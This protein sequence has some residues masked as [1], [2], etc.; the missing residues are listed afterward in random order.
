MTKILS[1]SLALS[2]SLLAV[3][4]GL[5]SPSARV[6]SSVANPAGA[7][8]SARTEL[9]VLTDDDLN[10]VVE[11]YC[12]RCHSDRRLTGNLS[13]EDYDVARAFETADVS[14]KLILKLRAGMMPPAGANRPAGD[15]L[16]V[17]VQTLERTIDRDRVQGAESR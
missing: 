11:G 15:T 10:E 3:S 9:A 5:G 17:L 12:V 13:L 7:P 6:A 1:L 16:A 2:G 14:E 4:M 8:E